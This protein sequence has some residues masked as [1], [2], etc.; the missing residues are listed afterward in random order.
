MRKNKLRESLQAGRRVFGTFVSTPEP[1]VVEMIGWAG[2][3][4]VIID[5]EHSPID[6]GQLP[7][8][9]AAAENVDLAPLVRVGSSAA[10]PILRVLDSGA[11]GV[12]VAHVRNREEALATVSAC[13]YPPLGKRGVS[14]ASRA[15]GY[16]Y[17]NF[18]DHVR[19]SNDEVLTIALIEDQSGVES[20]EEIVNVPGLDVICPGAGDLSAS[21]GLVGQPQHPT[22]QASVE[23]VVQAVNA[24]RE[25]VLGCHVMEPSQLGRCLELGAQ[26]IIYSQ[27]SRVIFHAYK[28]ALEVLRSE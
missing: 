20:I 5:M 1:A 2:Y 21:L 25:Q 10:N 28:T 27:D 11:V 4:F 23:R 15:A 19:Q 22:V 7:R 14:G 6:F 12:V 17:N 8:L 9:L 3:D 26:F 13:R 18:A 16:G 24:R